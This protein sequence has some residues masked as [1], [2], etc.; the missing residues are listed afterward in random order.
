M[1]K[2]RK[3]AIALAAELRL[4]DYELSEEAY[5]LLEKLEY[6]ILSSQDRAEAITRY[7]AMAFRMM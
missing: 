3:Q 6:F 5:G 1:G 4:L 7:K 2:N